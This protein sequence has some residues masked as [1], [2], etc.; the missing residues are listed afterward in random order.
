MSRLVDL[1]GVKILLLEDDANLG[2]LVQEHLTMHG[3]E[4]TL[5]SDGQAGLERFRQDHFHLCLVDIMMPR[6]DGFSFVEEIRRHDE[7]ISVIFLTAK[8]LKEDKIKGFKLGC[9]DY[10]TKPFSIEELLLRIQAILK[11]SHSG[12]KDKELPAIFQIGNYQ[13]DHKRQILTIKSKKYRLTAREADVLRLLCLH[14][15][16]TLER[17]VALLEI[18]GDDNYFNSRSM[19]VYITKLRKYLKEDPRVEILGIHGRGFR[20]TVD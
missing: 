15:N 19:D 7:Q 11:R 14:M 18:W 3:Y 16:E 17:G 12:L 20:L 4:V 6:M 13:F 5:C 9:D 10:L 8:S 2:A 1:K